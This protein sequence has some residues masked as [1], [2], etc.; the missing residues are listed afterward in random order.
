MPSLQERISARISGRISA[1]RERRPALDH[2]VRMQLHYGTVNGS[3]QAGAVTYFA[4][5]S[6]FPVLALSFFLVG[7]VSKVYPQAERD[8]VQAIEVVL[9]GILGTGTGELSLLD[10]QAAAGAVGLLGLVGV[11]YSGLGWLSGMRDALA[12]VFELPVKGQP[13]FVIGKLR[14]LVALPLIG[15]IL[16]LSVVISGFVS[17]FSEEV[18][19][20][21]GLS[22]A[23][24]PALQ[25]LTWVLGLAANAVLF[26]AMFR[27]L[28]E[29]PTPR[30]SLW[31]GAVLGAVG[32]E[33]LKR[34]SSLLLGLT[35]DQ[36]AFQTFGIALILVVWINYFSRVVLYAAA[37][38]HTSRAARAQ[39]TRETA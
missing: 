21:L 7:Y 24:S 29:P 5:L 20:L 1:I 35:K 2:L 19:D 9:P 33:V 4:F 39:R 26:F 8:L 13:N 6:V 34:L 23:L 18:L 28:A 14:D 38:A 17:S 15:A 16:I 11:V 37:W 25:V 32:F 31:S 12:E 10:I 36:P 22:E 27:M 3:Q 30:R